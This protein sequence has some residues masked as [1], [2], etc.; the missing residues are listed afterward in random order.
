M[1][2]EDLS[3]Q[4]KNSG[5]EY[6]PASAQARFLSGL[7]DFLLL[8]PMVSLVPAFHFR[9]AR[10]DYTQ[11]FD[12]YVMVHIGVLAF[13]THVMLQTGFLY[14][15]R[16]TP[17][18]AIM[19]LKVKTLSPGMS[20]NQ[21]LLR[22]TFY[23][24]SWLFLGLPLLEV[25]THPLRRCWH[26]RVSDTVVVGF[27]KRAT[28]FSS[29]NSAGIRSVMILGFFF[30]FLSAS[31][32][33]NRFDVMTFTG[34]MT[35]A[36]DIDTTVAKALLKKDTTEETRAEIDA[37]LW[38]ARTPQEKALAYFYRF[39]SESKDDVKKALSHQICDWK[40]HS[41]CLFTQYVLEPTA[42]KL[43][44]LT[45]SI[46]KTS[47]LS[48]QVAVM[49]ELTK[50]SRVSLAL[51]VYDDLKRESDIHDE[52]RIWDVSLFMKI[53]K[54]TTQDR[55]PASADLNKALSDYELER[56]EP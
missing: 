38:N 25:F 7:F 52:L 48:A 39:Q 33:M 28:A 8:S 35:S 26:D 45:A 32:L 3:F 53:R 40:V 36:Y 56:G 11:N 10:I 51:N 44:D 19:N 16:A 42:Q 17:G 46:E 2:I 47:F 1:V 49:K 5:T 43:V 29:V 34:N 15:F 27:E 21:A 50:Q 24:L 20:W 23:S 18:Q 13:L 41:L 9:E 31:S 4:A 37:L 6:Q 12:S 22:S 55:A 14:F 30:L 54:E